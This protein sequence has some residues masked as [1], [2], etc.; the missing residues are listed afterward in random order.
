M[1]KWTIGVAALSLL[2]LSGIKLLAFALH[3]AEVRGTKPERDTMINGTWEVVAGE[4][5][6]EPVDILKDIQF[7]GVQFVIE[8]DKI[9]L[10]SSRGDREGAL[11]LDASRNPNAMMI[12]LNAGTESEKL[13]SGIYS[14][15]G[16]TLQICLGTDGR[17][18]PA[19]F[20]TRP[21]EHLVL[22]VLRRAPFGK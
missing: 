8:E 18:R 1:R 16:E 9:T 19:E 10:R 15:E 7:K 11:K 22:F 14:I 13:F 21:G 5:N 3:A 12:T 2:A 17:A 4:R 6:G 20:R